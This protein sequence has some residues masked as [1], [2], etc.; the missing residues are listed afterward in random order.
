M[1]QPSDWA[2][3]HARELIGDAGDRYTITD[4]DIEDVALALDAARKEALEEAAQIALEY[5][6]EAG[7]S[8]HP[9]IGDPDHSLGQ[10]FAANI[11]AKRIR[12]LID[13]EPKA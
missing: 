10:G 9:D 12:A 3:K 8:E 2:K 13:K 11:I 7:A 1:T 5:Y 6:D 4:Q